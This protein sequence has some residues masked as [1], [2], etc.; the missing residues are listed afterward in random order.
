MGTFDDYIQFFE[1]FLGNVIVYEFQMVDWF[2]NGLKSEIKR[3][4]RL[5]C[6][7][8]LFFFFFGSN[9][10]TLFEAYTLA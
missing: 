4:I 1:L 9:P 8:T 7:H 2:L 6:P 10:H 3:P 5:Y